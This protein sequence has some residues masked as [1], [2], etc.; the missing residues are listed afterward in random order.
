MRLGALARA[1]EGAIDKG[2]GIDTEKA[3]DAL[4]ETWSQPPM[5]RT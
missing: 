4:G 2:L 5:P 1:L 3:K